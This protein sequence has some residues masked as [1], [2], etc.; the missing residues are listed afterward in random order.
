MAIQNSR[1]RAIWVERWVLEEIRILAALENCAMGKLV[2]SLIE[3]R[4]SDKVQ[5]GIDIHALIRNWKR[6]G[7]KSETL[8]EE[9][10]HTVTE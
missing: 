7:W 1:R 2:E 3:N 4:V 6:D 8:A 9:N 10:R 5:D